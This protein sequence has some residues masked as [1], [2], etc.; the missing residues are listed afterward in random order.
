MKRKTYTTEEL[1]TEMQKIVD[2]VVK[3]YKDE[4][5]AVDV[6]KIRELEEN[7]EDVKFLWITREA[8]TH[9]VLEGEDDYL[10]AIR[11]NYKD[12]MNYKYIE[13]E[14]EYKRGQW[15]LKKSYESKC[16]HLEYSFGKYRLDV[17]YKGNDFAQVTMRDVS[18]FFYPLIWS[19]D[20]NYKQAN[21]AIKR[22]KTTG[23]FD[24][25]VAVL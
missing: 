5:F 21:E 4:D 2:K 14:I 24:I 7:G 12:R 10:H 3:H 13:H 20:M 11:V 25:P 17:D 16:K 19:T 18:L 22:F 6:K 9:L 15:T 23:F 8:G 1:I